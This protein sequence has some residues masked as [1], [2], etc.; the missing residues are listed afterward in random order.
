MAGYFAPVRGRAVVVL[1]ETEISVLRSQAV[2]LLQLIG[3]GEEPAEGIDALLASAFDDGPDQPPEDAVL[4]RLFPDAYG[5]PGLVPDEDVRAASAEFRRY[6]END[7]R[8]RKRRDARALIHS[9]DTLLPASQHRVPLR[10]KPDECLP[11]LGALNDL[12]L[13]LGTRLEISA[14]GDDEKLFQL[15]DT[16]PRKQ[17][18]VV[19]LWL[20]GLQETL[21]DSLTALRS[22]TE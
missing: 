15:P 6:T 22:E 20:G 5:D 7:L 14:E 11:W 1:N 18:V 4:A 10:L 12:R 13:A 9:L 17:I 2:Q 21:I 16:D 8:S 3:P 19:F